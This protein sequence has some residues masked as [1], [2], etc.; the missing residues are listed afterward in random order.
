MM[1]L[2]L[3]GH[4]G[5]V[6]VLL[7]NSGPRQV[8]GVIS[9]LKQPRVAR[10]NLRVGLEVGVIFFANP[11]E[12]PL[13][14]VEYGLNNIVVERAL[15]QL[16]HDAEGARYYVHLLYHGRQAKACAVLLAKA[17]EYQQPVRSD[18]DRVVDEPQVRL[19]VV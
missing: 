13:D 10:N 18:V 17:R 6:L 5:R 16:L 11:L 2:Y 8:A 4:G 14:D 9:E 12:V 19:V 15:V 7:G 3:L 1:Q